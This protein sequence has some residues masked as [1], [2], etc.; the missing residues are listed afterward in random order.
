MLA[1]L[2]E[3]SIPGRGRKLLLLY[4]LVNFT[5]TRRTLNPRK[6]TETISSFF[7]QIYLAEHSENAQ[8]PEGDGNIQLLVET[9]CL[10]IPRRT[11]NP[12]KGTETYC[13]LKWP[14]AAVSL[15]ERSIPGRGR[16]Q[17][18]NMPSSLD[19]PDSEN[20]QS[21]EGDGNELRLE[22]LLREDEPSE[23]AQSPEGDGNY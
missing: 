10:R 6:G 11:L 3:R 21:P 14:A 7:V 2:G 19:R 16:K 9:R 23:N 22:L 17:L 18:E 8:S 20:A 1:L 13:W 12:R 15:G 4:I 5:L